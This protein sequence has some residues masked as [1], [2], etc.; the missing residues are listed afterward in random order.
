MTKEL[1]KSGIEIIGDIPWGAH[2][3][4]FYETKE[5]LFDILVP[6]FKAGL[7]NNEFCVWIVFPPH[8]E[9]ETKRALE[10]SIPDV[11]R[12]LAAGDLEIVPQTEWYFRDGTFDPRIINIWEEK[13][14]RAL[15]KGYE[16]MR[17]NANE[18]WLTREEWEAFAAYEEKLCDL[19]RGQRIIM[20]CTYPLALIQA[21]ELFDVARTHDFAI[22]RRRGTWEFVE[23]LEM[24]QAWSEMKRLNGQLEK[25]IA[26][27]TRKLSEANAELRREVVERKRIEASLRGSEERFSKIFRFSPSMHAILHVSND[28]FLDV[29][30]RWLEKFGYDRSEVVGRTT[31]DLGLWVDPRS[32]QRLMKMLREG[33]EVRNYE[34]VL[35][36]K[37]GEAV[38]FLLFALPIELAGEQYRLWTGFDITERKAMEEALKRREKELEVKSSS[39]QEANT[40]L[41]V[42]LSQREEDRKALEDAILANF[43]ERVIPY[44]QRLKARHLSEAQKGLLDAVESNL[45]DIF[46]PFLQKIAAGYATLTP[47][48]VQI[49]D[50]TRIGKTSKEISMLL[51]LSKRTVDTHKNNIRR[52][53]G[54][55]N[56]QANLQ[57]F[58]RSL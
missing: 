39:L 6:Y 47:M 4:Q 10:R 30:D 55:S 11:A 21:A 3:C 2:F 33:R 53:L 27:R 29:N 12:R 32:R 48:E 56:K 51:G 43:K 1:R 17:A 8:S 44:V 49:A 58:L 50:M 25:R 45:N 20:L 34:A 40:A 35:R 38:D 7:E 37:S 9:K 13:L 36:T 41:K 5:D 57:V 23:S 14:A 16:G 28:R 31:L 22:A 18:A 46:S 19:I 26:E 54:L 52:K 15:A 42:L 24:K